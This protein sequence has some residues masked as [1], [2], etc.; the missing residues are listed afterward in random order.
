MYHVFIVFTNGLWFHRT[1]Q[2]SELVPVTTIHGKFPNQKYT[3]C[4]YVPNVKLHFM[5]VWG[6][7]NYT[8][9]LTALDAFYYSYKYYDNPY[10]CPS[11]PFDVKQNKF[12]WN[13]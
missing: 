10:F 8:V 6:I 2:R 11:K 1:I 12:V 3:R 9:Q 5:P 13:L 7:V 4:V